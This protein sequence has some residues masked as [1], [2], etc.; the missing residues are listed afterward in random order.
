[1]NGYVSQNDHQGNSLY[2]LIS[3]IWKNAFLYSSKMFP[4]QNCHLWSVVFLYVW[5]DYF[6]LMPTIEEL[7]DEL[8]L[9]LCLSMWGHQWF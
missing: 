7:I 8:T 6:H 2:T 9:T 1:M 4:V 3:N 5:K